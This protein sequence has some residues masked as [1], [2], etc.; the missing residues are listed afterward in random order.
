MTDSDDWCFPVGTL[1]Q[2]IAPSSGRTLNTSIEVD[3]VRLPALAVERGKH[4]WWAWVPMENGWVAYILAMPRRH[5]DIEFAVAFISHAEARKSIDTG[6]SL[7]SHRHWNERPRGEWD[8]LET[9]RAWSQRPSP[10][11]LGGRS[12]A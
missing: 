10:E 5:D 6:A 2:E 3:G 9:L 12:R 1:Q 8:L 11:R 4:E 7:P